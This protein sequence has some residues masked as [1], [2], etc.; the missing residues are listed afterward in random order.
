M[1]ILLLNFVF[2]PPTVKQEVLTDEDDESDL[3]SDEEDDEPVVEKKAGVC[4]CVCVCVL[5]FVVC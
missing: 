5:C 3:F 1:S 2:R 4:V